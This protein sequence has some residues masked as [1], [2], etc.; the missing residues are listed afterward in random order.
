M[1]KVYHSAIVL[2]YKKTFGLHLLI[3]SCDEIFV[4]KY[5]FFCLASVSNTPVINRKIV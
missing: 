1:N 2:F 5:N 4:L 3:Y